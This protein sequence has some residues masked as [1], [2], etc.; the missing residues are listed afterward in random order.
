MFRDEASI[1]PSEPDSSS[2]QIGSAVGRI[3][4]E[5]FLVA[6]DIYD[7]AYARRFRSH[8]VT[9][10]KNF[11]RPAILKSLDHPSEIL[12]DDSPSYKQLC[13]VLI[14]LKHQN[15]EEVVET[16]KLYDG[17]PYSLSSLIE[18]RRLSALISDGKR[19]ELEQAAVIVESLYEA[20]SAAHS[21]NILHC[22]VNPENVI[23]SN[24]DDRRVRLINFGLAWPVD[25]HR[26]HRGQAG[27]DVDP[28]HYTAP[29]MFVQLSH[30][31]PASD[32]YSLAALTYRL[33]VG[34]V[35]FEASERSGL[36]RLIADG[37]VT[38]PS[39]LRTDVRLET[40]R[41]IL[42]GLAFESQL[43]PQDIEDFGSRLVL[44]LREKRTVPT[45]VVIPAIA[46]DAI[47]TPEPEKSEP[48]VLE[49]A[50]ALSPAEEAPIRRM[51]SAAAAPSTISDRAIIWSLIVLLLAGALSIPIGKNIF[52][53]GTTVS[54][55]GTMLARKPENT[56]KS[57]VRYIAEPDADKLQRLTVSTDTPGDLYIV[58]E[59]S[60]DASASMFQ[61]VV[62]FP[63]SGPS[64]EPGELV[65]ASDLSTAKPGQTMKAVWIVWT[66]VKNADLEDLRNSGPD[67]TISDEVSRKIKHFL[68]RNRDLR[69]ETSRDD[70]TGHTLLSG[71]GDRLVHRIS[72]DAN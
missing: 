50:K 62:P 51:R 54:A 58:K 34:R 53:D 36:L 3:L 63:N 33:L 61:A 13:N 60:T 70:A 52:S 16:G 55:T 48:I 8:I 64:I 32:I 56:T 67:K 4:Y 14:K 40:D 27:S 18:G 68:E 7:P 45:P 5:R 6:R 59:V 28:I 69:L 19:L 65:K 72:V 23:V 37:V 29:E 31:S 49:E 57:Q 24:G 71:T 26:E 46:A 30:R 20:L 42:A 38:P 39:E 11:C 41:I 21:K 12:E 47:E 2:P 43:R 35:P 22:D 44:S 10:L 25:L 9:D 66:A 17:R 15:I 1:L